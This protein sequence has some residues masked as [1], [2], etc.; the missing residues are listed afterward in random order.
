MSGLTTVGPSLMSG[1]R[2][3]ETTQP[4]PPSAY[5]SVVCISLLVTEGN[6]RACEVEPNK[7][8][9]KSMYNR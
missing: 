8:R 3:I 4:I 6:F 9:S 2:T 7:A 1:L 5:F